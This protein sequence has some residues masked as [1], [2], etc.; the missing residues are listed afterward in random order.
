M[1]FNK[2][3]ETDEEK[4]V[5]Q[6]AVDVIGLPKYPVGTKV[7][8]EYVNPTTGMVS[9]GAANNHVTGTGLVHSAK[10]YW[11]GEW[12]WQYRIKENPD[13]T[14]LKLVFQSEIKETG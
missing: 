11:C 9:W 5:F 7:S 6:E 1:A 12:C 10:P 4:K 8:F 3:Q 13:S 2:F 14:T